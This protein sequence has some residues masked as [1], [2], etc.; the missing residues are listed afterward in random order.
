L[1]R[2]PPLLN[3][4]EQSESYRAV[5]E[6]VNR[7][8]PRYQYGA[9]CLSDGVLGLWIARACGLDEDIV[10]PA[11]VS[12]HLLAVYRN[13]LKHDLSG[14]ANPQRPTY[15]MGSDGGLLLCTWPRGDK[16]LLPFV[17]SDEVWT[18]I[19]YQ[20]ASHLI[21]T[22]HLAEGLD[23]V[24]TCRSRHDG[25]RRNPFNEYEC[26]HWYARALSSYGLLQA[27]GGARYD[28]VDQVL[29]LRPALSGDYRVFLATASGY[30]T[31]GMKDG[32]PFLEVRSGTIAV[33][34]IDL[35]PPR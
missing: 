15:A 14:H 3:P 33:N 22:G 21:L 24:R 34:R 30:G 28:A 8:G 20:V 4:A 11:K 5:A 10:A 2:P 19:E 6:E 17:Y 23:I 31:A 25:V 32:K 1:T 12:S 16:P 35:A 29:Y 26:G 18:G 7:Q 27:L 13:N 9:G